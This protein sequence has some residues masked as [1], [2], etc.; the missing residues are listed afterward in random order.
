M[1]KNRFFGIVTFIVGV[2][3]VFSFVGCDD[4]GGD[5][6]DDSTSGGGYKN[7]GENE[8]AGKTLYLNS[9]NKIVFADS[10]TAFKGWRN[11]N[12]NDELDNEGSYS[13]NSENKTIT[14][15]LQYI[16]TYDIYVY[17]NN[18]NLVGIDIG[19]TKRIMMNKTQYV[20]YMNNFLN[21]SLKNIEDQFAYIRKDFDAYIRENMVYSLL[22]DDIRNALLTDYM[23]Y[24][25]DYYNE[26]GEYPDA[27]MIKDFR[28]KWIDQWI[29]ENNF[30]LDAAIIAWK[31]E[32]GIT[33]G[34]SYI[35]LLMEQLGYK[36]LDELKAEYAAMRATYQSSI[37]AWFAPTVY[38]YQI[39][40]D[41][42][43]LAQEKLPAN[44]GVNEF[45]G[46]I[47]YGLTGSY[48]D[49]E[50]IQIPD[51]NRTYVFTASDY[52][53]TERRDYDGYVYEEIGS[54][55]YDSSNK[56]VWLK[57]ETINGKDQL[58]YYEGISGY[59]YNNDYYN[60]PDENAYRAGETNSRF[61][62]GGY[63]YNNTDKTIWYN[64]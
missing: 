44:K 8:V 37:E 24:R 61:S 53:F 56:Q 10:G 57:P 9:Y 43:L 63:L 6:G 40:D 16:Y 26:N 22:P 21:A 31:E 58:E 5:N 28:D 41:G 30:D 3:L 4:G 47:Y 11:Y 23:A 29:E 19:S 17:D 39:T 33:D 42:S 51:E 7:K 13:Y 64:K 27:D 18:G 49:G 36:N 32:N 60:Y 54:Y 52:T 1:S 12:D 14:L 38:V 62:F 2:M 46:Q 50:Y 25:N 45:S 20:Q 55:A 59:N 35:N 34:N 15:T 48:V